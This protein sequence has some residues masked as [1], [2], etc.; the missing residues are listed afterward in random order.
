MQ[1]IAEYHEDAADSLRTF[2]SS[3]AVQVNL[4]Y[5]FSTQTELS[6][7]LT[8]RLDETEL[9]SCLAILSSIEAALRIDYTARCSAR[10]KDPLSRDFRNL[11]KRYGNR[12]RLEE[13]IL[14]LWSELHPELKR[15]IG[16]LRGALKF[17]HWLA[18][19]RHWELKKRG[20]RYDFGEVFLLASVI[21]D[22]FPLVSG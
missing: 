22:N 16:E 13:D 21:R 15:A 17:R 9:R 6:A 12:V 8:M 11:F 3:S 14:Q 4:R 1:E 5:L 7:I 19:G 20:R 2:F 10:S 18:H